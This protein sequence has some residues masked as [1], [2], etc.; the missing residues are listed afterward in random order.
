[1]ANKPVYK[2]P[3]DRKHFLS[4]IEEKGYSML[5]LSAECPGFD[6]TAR[7]L[8]RQLQNGEMPT[9]LLF[10]IARFL[11]VEPAYLSGKASEVVG[12]MWHNLKEDPND[13]PTKNAWYVVKIK[14]SDDLTIVYGHENV[15][16]NKYDAWLRIDCPY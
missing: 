15:T 2:I 16:T 3:V 12:S 9:Q 8:A 5:R 7:T 11:D 13:L 1:M 4:V 14:S 6:R 10:A